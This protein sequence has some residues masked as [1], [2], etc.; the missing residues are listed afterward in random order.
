[1]IIALTSDTLPLA[2]VRRLRRQHPQPSRSRA[3]TGVGQVFVGGQQKPAVRIQVDP[4]KVAAL[5]LQ[6]DGVRIG[7]R[8]QTVNAP[9]GRS[10]A[11]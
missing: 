6:L 7:H 8:R 1:M 4:R 3:S 9:K 11:R 2:T 10:T 5:G